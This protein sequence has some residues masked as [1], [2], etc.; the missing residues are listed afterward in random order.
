[1]EPTGLLSVE[2]ALAK[3]RLAGAVQ[4]GGVGEPFADSAILAR[5]GDLQTIITEW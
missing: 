4:D 5:R 3:H 2:T 1:M